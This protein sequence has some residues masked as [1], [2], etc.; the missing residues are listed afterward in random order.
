MADTDT[1]MTKALQAALPPELHT[2]IPSLVGLF[3]SLTAEDALSSRPPLTM[4]TATALV[5]HLAG[6]E[7]AA[8]HSIVSFGEQSQ[9]G[10]V[11]I[12]DVAG[13]NVIKHNL[14]VLVGPP[15]GDPP[16]SQGAATARAPGGAGVD[17]VQLRQLIE[18]AFNTNEIADLCFDMGIDHEQLPR[19]EKSAMIRELILYCERH[20]R[21]ADL[22]AQFRRLR[23]DLA[24]LLSG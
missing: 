8:E 6:K 20:N 23:P 1:T 5:A 17:R 16:Q 3:S 21:V 9:L 19:T 7:L 24:A 22:L 18:A 15:P 2:Y 12:H 11:T 13:N 10:D 14:F 4:K